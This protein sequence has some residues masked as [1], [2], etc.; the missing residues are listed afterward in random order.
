MNKSDILSAFQ[1]A[2][3]KP[4][5]SFMEQWISGGGKVI[6]HY[7]SLIP[8]EIFTAADI[9]S[10]R[11]RVAGSESTDLADTYVSS[12]VCTFVRHMLNLALEGQFDFLSGI[13]A[14]NGCDQAR[15]AYDIW[16]RK[17]G[18]PFQMI[19][20]VPRTPEEYNIGWYK[21]ELKRLI[22]AIE[23]H[24]SVKISM[25]NLTE[26]IKLHNDVRRKLAQFN[27][28]RKE[29]NPV[30]NGYEATTVNIAAQIMPL[31]N[32]NDLLDKLL[33]AVTKEQSHNRYRARLILSGGEMDEP[34]FV[35]V[36]EEQ[37]GLVV[38]EDMCFGARYYEEPVREEGDPLTRIAERYFYRIPCA[39]MGNGFDKRYENLKMIRK[40]FNAEGIISQLIVHC[41]L[42]A[43][44]SFQ[45]KRKVKS[46]EI[47][48]LILDRECRMKGYGQIKTRV[49]AFIE[50]IESKRGKEDE[51]KCQ[52]Q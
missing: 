51:Y 18:I 20:S 35:K 30:I 7:C 4:L 26:A 31:K 43:G 12:Q 42:N 34:E 16:K 22:E 21:K 24:F 5:N 23:N 46:D 44:L 25:Q 49:Q 3:K 6:G 1:Q 33:K 29:P 47:P 41:I 2:L 11:I 15:R 37:G 36:I 38:Y 28:L 10:Y 13:V 8:Q 45:F 17:T 27:D 39:R 48:L 19:I 40:E 52:K 9:A 50:S 14:M 32:V